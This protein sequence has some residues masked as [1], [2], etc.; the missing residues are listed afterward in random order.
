V[1]MLLSL[2]EAELQV[3]PQQILEMRIDEKEIIEDFVACCRSTR[4]S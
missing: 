2:L 3:K 1:N 4:N